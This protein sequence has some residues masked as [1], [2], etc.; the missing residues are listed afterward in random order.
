M[1][2]IKR[3]LAQ[4]KQEAINILQRNKHV[5]YDNRLHLKAP[6]SFTDNDGNVITTRDVW[7]DNT[8]DS[9]KIVTEREK[10]ISVDNVSGNDINAL[11]VAI[12]GSQ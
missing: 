12:Q 2:N 6:I 11:Y 1:S 3:I 4:S 7:Y 5:S 9:L 10:I 8:E